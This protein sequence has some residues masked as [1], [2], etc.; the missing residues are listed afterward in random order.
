[1]RAIDQFHTSAWRLAAA[2]W[3]MGL[4]APSSARRVFIDFDGK[5]LFI[6]AAARPSGLR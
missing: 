5:T 4:A 3:V 2:C 6:E 1:M